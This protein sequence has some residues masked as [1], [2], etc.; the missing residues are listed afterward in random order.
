M[1]TDVDEGSDDENE[2]KNKDEDGNELV[3]TPKSSVST[4]KFA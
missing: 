3:I 1:S 4:M 2:D